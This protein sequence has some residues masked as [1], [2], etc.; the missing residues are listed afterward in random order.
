ME[1][2]AATIG[3]T[4][5]RESLGYDGSGVGVAIIDSGVTSW[6]DDL[7][8][9]EA[10]YFDVVMRRFHHGNV[11]FL[12]DAAHAMSPQLGQGAN[13]ALTD[14]AA[15]ADAL[16]AEPRLDAALER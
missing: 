7:A 3:A 6:H 4:A 1:R 14:A 8:S 13:L 12:G 11:V 16:A 2:T 9:G 10:R 5:V 15:L